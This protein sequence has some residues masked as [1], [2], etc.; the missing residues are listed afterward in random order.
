MAPEAVHENMLAAG[1]RLQLSTIVC[2]D[3]KTTDKHHALPTPSTGDERA[4]IPALRALQQQIAACQV[5]LPESKALAELLDKGEGLQQ[6]A[7][8]SLLVRQSQ[9]ELAQL[10]VDAEDV[11]VYIADVDAVRGLM[12]K[13]QDWLRRAN[14]AV[15]RVGWACAWLCCGCGCGCGHVHCQGIT[16]VP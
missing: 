8:H 1:H 4:D 2:C 10:V 15:E 14:D 12:A 6:R 5:N 7:R 13:A 3:P 11:A 16:D 9:E